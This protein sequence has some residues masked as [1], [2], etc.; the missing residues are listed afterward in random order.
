MVTP[1]TEVDFSANSRNNDHTSQI[2]PSNNN[3][4]DTN[5]TPTPTPTITIQKNNQSSNIQ[6]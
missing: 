2:S 3:N 5:T 4:T 1:T 6:K